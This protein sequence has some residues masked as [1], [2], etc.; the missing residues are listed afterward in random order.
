MKKIIDFIKKELIFMHENYE[1]KSDNSFF[2]GLFHIILW[3]GGFLLFIF[4]VL[5]FIISII[6][7]FTL[8]RFEF[9]VFFITF[10]ALSLSHI[11]KRIRVLLFFQKE[12]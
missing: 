9:G 1:T 10:G 5:F 8:G 7:S 11:F 2:M 12:D 6:L 3:G 4:G